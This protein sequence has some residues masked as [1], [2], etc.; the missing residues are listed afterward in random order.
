MH[1]F[2]NL[3]LAVVGLYVVHNYLDVNRKIIPF[4]LIAG[5]INILFSVSQL[6]GFNPVF[7]QNPDV[8]GA[9]LGNRARL[10]NYLTLIIAFFPLPLV[11]LSSLL[12]LLTKQA[13]ILIPIVLTVFI[14]LRNFKYRVAFF[15]MCLAV[16]FIIR[17]HIYTE[18]VTQRVK[19]YW[20]PALEAFFDRPLIGYGLGYKVIKDVG[21]VFNSYLQ[22]IVGVGILGAVWFG[23]MFKNIFKRIDKSI[24]SIAFITLALLMLIE[25]PVEMPR[26]WFLIIGI[27][28]MFLTKKESL[29]HSRE[30]GL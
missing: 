19:I 24:P 2:L 3:F 16:M 30:T 13:V 11:M 20:I 17:N 26:L 27:I 29:C 6:L 25:Y 10:A 21:A 12:A 1:N 28:V 15:I 4:I 8:G 23:Y 5:A 9:F 18:L 7:N 22:F 14:R